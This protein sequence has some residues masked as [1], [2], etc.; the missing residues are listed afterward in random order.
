MN[1]KLNKQY[2]EQKINPIV[3]PMAF[4]LFAENSKEEDPVSINNY[5]HLSLNFQIDFMIKYLKQN[6][7]NRPS[8]I[9]ADRM[10]LEF[11]RQEVPTLRKNLGITNESPSGAHSTASDKHEKSSSSDDE[12]E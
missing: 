1:E 9:E 11:L 2:I 12:D 4:A 10:E 6:Y 5:S 8:V 3:E 7:G